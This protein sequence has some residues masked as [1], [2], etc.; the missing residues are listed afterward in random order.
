MRLKLEMN[1]DFGSK[2][3]IPKCSSDPY[4][5]IYLLFNK[6]RITKKKTHIKKRTL[7]P[8]F[9]ESFVFDLPKTQDSSLDNIQV[10][11]CFK[12]PGFCYESV[13]IDLQL[14]F[15]MLDWDRVTKNEV[16]WK[17]RS[18]ENK[19]KNQVIGKLELGR[20]GSEGS[21][22]HHWTEIQVSDISQILLRYFSDIS[23]IFLRYFSY[24]S[25]KFLRYFSDWSPIFLTFWKILNRWEC[26]QV[27]PRRQIAE[28]HRLGD[29]TLSRGGL[30]FEIIIWDYHYII[31]LTF[32]RTQCNMWKETFMDQIKHF[33]DCRV[34]FWLS[35][36]LKFRLE[37]M[38]FSLRARV[39]MRLSRRRRESALNS[40]T[41]HT[42]INIRSNSNFLIENLIIWEETTWLCDKVI[43]LSSL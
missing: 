12:S 32:D 29:W 41:K 22:L 26:D 21:Q 27:S 11:N 2:V 10:A 39:R 35:L 20:E 28:W 34:E 36:A 33:N 18:K 23:Q 1:N 14:E 31:W 37:L 5:K 42:N 43:Y 25:W 38:L 15:V 4:V 13:N 8:V 3:V 40:L 19:K 17:R 7:N 24:I 6:Q 16:T 9:N 30:S